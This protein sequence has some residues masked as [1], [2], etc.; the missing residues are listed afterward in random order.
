MLQNLI[1]ELQNLIKT[2]HRKSGK[3]K[4]D[5]KVTE[6]DHTDP[7]SCERG[8]R[9]SPI[10]RILLRA[11]TNETDG[12]CMAQLNHIMLVVQTGIV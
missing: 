10:S 7:V 2:Y 12:T 8:L 3:G 5:R 4:C 9:I 11:R 6:L 1:T